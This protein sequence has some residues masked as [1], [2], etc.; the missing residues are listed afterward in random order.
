MVE[1][2]IITGK[3]LKS[4]FDCVS[5]MYCENGRA[6]VGKTTETDYMYLPV[7]ININGTANYARS[8]KDL[9]ELGYVESMADGRFYASENDTKK[10]QQNYWEP[11]HGKPFTVNK[12]SLSL[13]EQLRYGMKSSTFLISEGKKYTFGVEI[14][15]NKGF[16]PRHILWGWNAKVVR[17]GSINRDGANGGEYVTGILIGDSGLKHVQEMCYELGKRCTVNQQCGLH[18][19][20]GGADFNKEL[21]IYSYILGQKLQHEMFKIVPPS[22]VNNHYCTYLP[23]KDFSEMK[24]FFDGT[25]ISKEEYHD[26]IEI[27]YADIFNYLSGGRLLSSKLNKKVP[28]PDGKWCKPRYHWLNLIPCNFSKD[29][30]VGGTIEF[31]HHSGTL[32][33]KKIRNYIL[34]AMAFVNYVE[35]HKYDIVVKK[36]ITMKDILCAAYPNKGIK[37][38]TYFEE[39]KKVFNSASSSV[40][41]TEYSSDAIGNE[42]QRIREMI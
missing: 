19:H 17:D 14:E 32:N 6:C 18:V 38:A 37:I 23:K 3:K 1:N 24:K 31:R 28:H 41:K 7:G 20:I 30:I 25:K 4:G 9:K 13:S 2:D 10:A 21:N 34:L 35:N 40:E 16:V 26:T 15:T 5:I 36:S 12:E 27:Y 11:F 22:R 39:R 29:G 33:F 42:V 8:I